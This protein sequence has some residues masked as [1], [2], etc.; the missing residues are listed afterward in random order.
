M[1]EAF[2]C[3]NLALGLLRAVRLRDGWC[4]LGGVTA[5]YLLVADT[6]A[7]FPI[8]GPLSILHPFAVMFF[9]PGILPHREAGLLQLP[10]MVFPEPLLLRALRIGV[11]AAVAWRCLHLSAKLNPLLARA[12]ALDAVAVPFTAAGV[13]DTLTCIVVLMAR[14]FASLD[15]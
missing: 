15:A 3:V 7:V 13:L 8:S 5:L 1:L 9:G 11:C 4:L 6:L 12:Y 2:V 10:A 14:H